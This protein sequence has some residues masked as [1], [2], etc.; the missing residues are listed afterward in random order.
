MRKVYLYLFIALLFLTCQ[1]GGQSKQVYL[2]KISAEINASTERV[3]EDAIVTA[4]SEDASALIIQ[5][6]TPGG[7]GDA[8][9]RIIQLIDQSQIPVLIYVAPQGAIAASAGTFISMGAHLVVMAPGTSMGACEPIIGYDPTTGQIQ[10][11]PEK[12]K[13]FYAGVMRSLAESHGRDAAL[14]EKF[15]LENLTLTAD[16]A[17]EAG[18][19]DV[20]ASNLTE[21]LEKS[22]G[23]ET[24]GPVFGEVQVLHLKDAEIVEIQMGLVDRILS[25]I[26]NPTITYV[27]F[28][29][30][31]YGL[32]FGFLSPGWHVPETLGA[33]CLILALI[34]FGYINLNTGGIILI[35]AA[36]VFFVIEAATPTFGLFVSAGAVCV[37]FGSLMLFRVGVGDTETL[38][39]FVSREWYVEFRYVVIAATIVTV[40]FFAFALYKVIKL[41]LTKAR[42]GGEE[43]LGM[44]GRAVEDLDPEGQIKIRGER[45]KA[46]SRQKIKKGEKVRVIDRKGLLLIVE[47][48]T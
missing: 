12:Y 8:M 10:E 28:M 26:T 27:L 34:G 24:R 46:E 23:M 29:I 19:A 33:V 17:L 37:F 42:T 1:T 2:I 15:V 6:D 47:K 13:R 4:M 18:M 44:V 45:W 20:I 39:R 3:F 35:I 22:E 7:A 9:M 5:L 30:G 36:C 16:E 32:I 48:E 38:S 41:R 14:A 40:T 25:V 43:I 11:A 21:V 31:I